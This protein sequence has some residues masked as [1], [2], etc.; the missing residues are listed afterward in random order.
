M[1]LSLCGISPSSWRYSAWGGVYEDK[2]GQTLYVNIGIGT[3]LIPTR[4]GA[5]PE[6]TILTLRKAENK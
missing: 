3:V 5:T 1:Q 6:I 4:I 2:K